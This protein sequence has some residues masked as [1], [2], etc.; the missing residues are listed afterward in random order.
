MVRKRFRKESWLSQKNCKKNLIGGGFNPAT[1][2]IQ[3]LIKDSLLK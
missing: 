2:K 3:E 1:K